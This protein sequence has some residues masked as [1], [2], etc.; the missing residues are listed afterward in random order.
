MNIFD[1]ECSARFV[2][3]TRR[4]G[5]G[6]AGFNPPPNVARGILKAPHKRVASALFPLSVE[7]IGQTRKPFVSTRHH[8][9][10][11]I[12]RVHRPP[13][14]LNSTIGTHSRVDEW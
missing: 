5:S 11:V 4:S 3:S 2:C 7:E 13:H 14:A 9:R 6:C 8:N 12:V 10:R 1:I